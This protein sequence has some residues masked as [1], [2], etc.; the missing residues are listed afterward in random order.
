[1]TSDPRAPGAGGGEAG[2]RNFKRYNKVLDGVSQT[3][4]TRNQLYLDHSYPRE[5]AFIS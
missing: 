1:M 5:L 3:K 4:H 2:R